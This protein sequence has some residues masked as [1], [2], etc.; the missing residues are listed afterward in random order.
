LPGGRS[1]RLAKNRAVGRKN[2]DLSPRIFDIL[3]QN[4]QKE[5]QFAM[6]SST[7]PRTEPTISYQFVTTLFDAVREHPDVIEDGLRRYELRGLD[8]KT[9]KVSLRRYIELFEW[10][11]RTLDRP[12]L[13]LELSQLGG[14]EMLGVISYLFFASPNLESAIRN[15]G[16]YLKA[17][18][19]HSRLAIEID[20]EYAHI[21]YGILDDRITQRRQDS[22]YSLGHTWHL[23]KLFSDNRCQLT[24]VEFEHDRPKGGDG[25]YRRIFGAP[26]LFRR[27]ANR[28]HLRTEQL[29]V[30]SRSGDPNL[31]PILEAHIQ[32]LI[33][34][35]GHADTFADQVRSQL[36]HEAI[37]R[38][39]RAKDVAQM[40]GISVATLHRR[41][42]RENTTFKALSDEASKS[43]AALLIEQRSLPVATLAGRLGYSE[44]A[45]LTRA[46]RRWFG[47]SPREYRRSLAP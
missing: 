6:R 4:R 33:A 9:A 29:N 34:R 40:L 22:E 16:H 15:F 41:L 2:I 8:P 37:G 19:E 14:P 10:L 11:A 23:M 36:T 26:V 30:P 12:W 24:M 5:G 3:S 18:Q 27:R 46:F 20:E 47:M 35:S 38:G 7:A 17:L 44:T 25:P 21:D 45:A 1:E 28:L 42:A 32:E 13:G 31:Y 43:L 39:V